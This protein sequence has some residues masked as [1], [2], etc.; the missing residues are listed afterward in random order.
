MPGLGKKKAEFLIVELKDK[1]EARFADVLSSAGT[2]QKPGV[3]GA[4]K[5]GANQ[6]TMQDILMGL[7]HMGYKGPNVE[8]VV[9]TVL[10]DMGDRKPDFTVLFAYNHKDGG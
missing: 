9:R 3:Q 4:A 7:E 8:S 6:G 1:C 2:M 10:A 5:L